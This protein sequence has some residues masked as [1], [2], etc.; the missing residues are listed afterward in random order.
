MLFTSFAMLNRAAEKGVM[1]TEDAGN[2]LGRIEVVSDKQGLKDCDI[3]VEA[4]VEQLEPKQALFAELEA[5]VSRDCILATNTS[6][7]S[8]TAIGARCEHRDRV[9]G[10]HFFNPVPLMPLVEI[11]SGDGTDPAFADRAFAIAESWGKVTARAAAPAAWEIASGMVFG[12]WAAPQ[13]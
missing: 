3:V 1:S 5:I 10:Y 4:I 2:A 9:A 11:I 12:E 8:V 13:R 6:S 7:L